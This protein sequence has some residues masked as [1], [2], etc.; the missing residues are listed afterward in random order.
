MTKKAKIQGK[1]SPGLAK[2]QTKRSIAIRKKVSITEGVSKSKHEE[3]AYALLT[4]ICGFPPQREV[5]FH[6]TRRWRF[7]FA[8][9]EQ[10]IAI[11]V[12][13]GTWVGGRHV[14]PSGYRSD[15]EKYN[16]AARLGWRVVRVVPELV[17]RA[18]FEALFE[19]GGQ[20][21]N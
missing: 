8:Y 18:Y 20:F 13:G 6:P 4:E 10:R 5:K 21:K 16:Q 3:K 2:K 11:E 9:V 15:C 12:E 17:T 19:N 7:D 1:K 14:H